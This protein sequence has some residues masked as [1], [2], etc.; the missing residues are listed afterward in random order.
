MI[1]SIVVPTMSDIIDSYIH[2]LST[3]VQK[4]PRSIITSPMSSTQ[5]L[6]G[7]FHYE[8]KWSCS[9]RFEGRN[10]CEYCGENFDCH[11]SGTIMFYDRNKPYY[12]FTNF[13]KEKFWIGKRMIK[14]SEHLFQAMK[15]YLAGDYYHGDTVLGLNSARDALHYARQYSH[16]CYDN[17]HGAD[18]F[19]KI[20]V[21][22]LVMLFCCYHKFMSNEYLYEML[23]GTGNSELIEDASND[24]YWGRGANWAGEN[25][26]G[27]ILMIIRT[28]FRRS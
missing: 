27:R 3:F 2:F 18:S 24:E 16:L 13:Y 19:H 25:H 28:Y 10:F 20:P 6:C 17:W 1:F 11:K 4:M 23:M 8:K 7:H 26:L 15:F 9:K 21:K 22:N 12:E 14:T 5:N